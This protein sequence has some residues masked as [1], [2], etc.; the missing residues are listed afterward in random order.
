[1]TDNLKESAAELDKDLSPSW[2]DL[3]SKVRTL[4]SDLKLKSAATDLAGDAA[5]L[6]QEVSRLCDH[7]EQI[8]A[9]VIDLLENLETRIP[10]HQEGKTQSDVSC[11]E[12]E[13]ERIQIQRESHELRSDFKDVLKALFMWV[14]DPKERLRDKH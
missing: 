10:L 5:H 8:H 3:C 14:D 11:D 12:V 9:D 13:K 6:S 1:M 7:V 4:A 2:I